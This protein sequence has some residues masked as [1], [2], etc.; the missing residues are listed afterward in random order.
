M[1]KRYGYGIGW[2]GQSLIFCF[3]GLFF[4]MVVV[5]N[6]GSMYHKLSM[7]ATSDLLTIDLPI[8]NAY[9]EH[10]RNLFL[11]FLLFF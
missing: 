9:F 10:V 3:L 11:G 5:V 1:D 7:D 8:Q 6:V 4:L 2:T